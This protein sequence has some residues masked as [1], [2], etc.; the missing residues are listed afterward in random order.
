MY[1]V[2]NDCEGELINSSNE[3]LTITTPIITDLGVLEATANIKPYFKNI[4]KLPYEI[5]NTQDPKVKFG[6]TVR[7]LKEKNLKEID[8]GYAVTAHKFQG[9]QAPKVLVYFEYMQGMDKVMKRR[10]LYTAV[11]R[12]E[13]KLIL[14]M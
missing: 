11:T 5:E 3:I 12:A 6:R 13:E 9:S 1:Y 8:F 10:W 14:V 7:Y 2:T 4:T